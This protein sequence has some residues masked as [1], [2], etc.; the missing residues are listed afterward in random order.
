MTDPTSRRPNDCCKAFGISR[1]TLYR[2][3]SA[4]E[5]EAFRVGGMTFIL[6]ESVI[7]WQ[8]RH[9]TPLSIRT[10]VRIPLS[11]RAGMKRNGA[12]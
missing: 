9:R 5:I 3:I 10:P 8:N 6:N 11:K 1:A 2:L 7:N 4:G 12:A